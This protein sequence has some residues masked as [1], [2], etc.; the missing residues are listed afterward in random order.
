M[1]TEMMVMLEDEDVGFVT[2]KMK[3]AIWRWSYDDGCNS[4]DVIAWNCML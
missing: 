3:M 4:G 1:K 2:M